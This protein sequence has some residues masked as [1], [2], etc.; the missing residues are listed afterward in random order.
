MFFNVVSL[1]AVLL[2]F[3]VLWVSIAATIREN[4]WEMAVIRSL[5]LGAFV[6]QRL[7]IYEALCVVLSSVILGTII[8]LLVSVTLILQFNLFTGTCNFCCLFIVRDAIRVHIPFILV[9]QHCRVQ[10]DHGHSGCLH[11]IKNG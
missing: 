9:L 1:V 4:S 8:G 5:G 10:L 2:C 11:T 6:V 3:F 7:Y